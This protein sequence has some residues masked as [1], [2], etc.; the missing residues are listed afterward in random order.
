MLGGISSRIR[1]QARDFARVLVLE[2]RVEPIAKIIRTLRRSRCPLCDGSMRDV[3]LP[4][5]C[6]VSAS[7]RS[8]SFPISMQLRLATTY[9]SLPSFLAP[10]PEIS[11]PATSLIFTPYAYSFF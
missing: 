5:V 6:S 2:T 9:H 10:P 8:L 11:L 7:G 4:P 3:L 1:V